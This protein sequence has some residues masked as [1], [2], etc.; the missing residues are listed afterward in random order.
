MGYG[1]SGLRAALR[2]FDPELGFAFST[3]AC[4][5]INGAIRDG[6]RGESPLPKRLT[7]LARSASAA[8]EILTQKLSRSP[9]YEEI[10]TYLDAGAHSSLLPRLGT[11]ASLDELTDPWRES[12]REPSCL[13]DV[14]DPGEEAWRRMQVEAV[15][16]ALAGLPEDQADLMRMVYLEG[17][18]LAETARATGHD[19]KDLRKLK[20]HAMTSLSSAL[21]QWR[22]PATV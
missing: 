10:T 14:S 18:S 21:E 17:H 2:A 19:I 3:Y 13:I 4:P 12:A 1:W 7:T 11:A 15:H 9:T 6:I 20:R 16:A 22:T 8:E 5:K